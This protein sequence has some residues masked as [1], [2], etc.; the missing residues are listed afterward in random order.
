MSTFGKFIGGDVEIKDNVYFSRDHF[1]NFDYDEKKFC[2]FID[3]I[4][5]VW[6]VDQFG[7]ISAGSLTVKDIVAD[8]INISCTG[9]INNLVITEDLCVSGTLKVNT[10]DVEDLNISG[11][12]VTNTLCVTSDAI[13]KD[14]VTIFW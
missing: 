9:F 13:F 4:Q 14:D 1:L 11:D 3:R 6:C 8:T 10:I 12:L 7:G 5:E 2:F